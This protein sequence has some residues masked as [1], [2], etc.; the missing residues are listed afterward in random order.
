MAAARAAGQTGMVKLVET[1]LAM[2]Q[3]GQPYRE[4]AQP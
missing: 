2:Y 3:D 1:Q 4:L